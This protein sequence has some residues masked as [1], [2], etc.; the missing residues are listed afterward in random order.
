MQGSNLRLVAAATALVGRDPPASRSRGT[1]ARRWKVEITSGSTAD[2]A[3]KN[4]SE[5]DRNAADTA[6]ATEI[7]RAGLR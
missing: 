5:A 2:Y 1:T 3:D 4:G 7:R 6:A